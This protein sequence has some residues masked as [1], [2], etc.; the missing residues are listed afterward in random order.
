MR[1]FADTVQV[2][3]AALGELFPQE[4]KVHARRGQ[5]PKR[6][7]RERCDA[8]TPKQT[9]SQQHAEVRKVQAKRRL[10]DQRDRYTAAREATQAP[11]LSRKQS[12]SNCPDS[13]PC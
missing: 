4:K 5:G 1:A 13:Q 9:K 2:L 10:S 3:A 8:A 12:S 7:L 6:A 11:N